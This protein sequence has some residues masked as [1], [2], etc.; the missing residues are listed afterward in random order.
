[1]AD[2]SKKTKK[3]VKVKKP[4]TVAPDFYTLRLACEAARNE[5]E[6]RERR[7]RR[8]KA[9]LSSQA[10]QDRQV[11]EANAELSKAKEYE[12]AAIAAFLKARGPR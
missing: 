3:T 10:D 9:Q 4:T 8:A 5:V 7:V 2:T 6:F 12:A 11:A 1:M